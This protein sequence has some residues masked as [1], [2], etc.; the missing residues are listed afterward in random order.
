LR[1]GSELARLKVLRLAA[2]K[3]MRGLAPI[4]SPL[5]MTIRVFTD[6]PKGDLDNFITGIF[7]GLMA[8]HPNTPIDP[9]A[10]VDIP[11]PAMPHRPLCF[12]DDNLISHIFAVRLP[13]DDKGARYSIE[14]CW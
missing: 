3:S 11:E 6:P 10:W 1:K 2:V 12:K 7:D 8:A 13:I 9:A 5:L 14:L 4:E